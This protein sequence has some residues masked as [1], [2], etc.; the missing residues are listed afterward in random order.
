MAHIEG[1]SGNDILSETSGVD[2]ILGFDGNDQISGGAGNDFLFG[3][4]GDDIIDGGADF[5]TVFIDN[6]NSNPVTINLLTGTATGADS[7]NDTLI[8]I[9][10][11]M[12]EGGLGDIT[13]IGSNGDDVLQA[14]GYGRNTVSGG[15]GDDTIGDMGHASVL[16][17][18]SGHNGLTLYR[19]QASDGTTV[20]T[21]SIFSFTPGVAGTLNDGTSYSNFDYLWMHTGSGDDVG[22]FSQLKKRPSTDSFL[23]NGWDAGNGNDTAIVDLSNYSTMVLMNP[24]TTLGSIS[25]YDN[26][27]P[28]TTAVLYLT[29]IENVRISGG[30]AG[31]WL[32]G[33]AGSDVFTGNGGD[34]RLD[35]GGGADIA[36]Y[37]GVASNY[38]IDQL[39]ATSFKVTDLRTGSPDGADTLNNIER[40]QWGDGSITVLRN[41]PPT[42]VTNTVSGTRYLCPHQPGFGQRCRW[43]RRCPPALMFIC[44]GSILASFR[45][46]GL[47][48]SPAKETMLFTPSPIRDCF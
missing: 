11:V 10:H 2:D 35:G 24:E 37:S 4:G 27:A 44:H 30:S 31:D 39:S 26:G 47:P 19:N 20:T 40:L 43:R 46:S 48:P 7:G 45:I 32:T 33:A 9:E 1:T 15:A 25:I 5:D 13:I 23:V 18:G 38:R 21:P 22:T 42:V 41:S 16:D 29:G 17:G 14:Y 3:Q 34:D 36:R 28:G 12:A 6:F 8:S